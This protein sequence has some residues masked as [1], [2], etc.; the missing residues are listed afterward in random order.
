MLVNSWRLG[1]RC[2]VLLDTLTDDTMLFRLEPP[3]E[4]LRKRSFCKE[5]FYGDWHGTVVPCA[6]VMSNL[7]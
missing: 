1:R 7:L 4:A 6:T 5:L 2:Y 3:R